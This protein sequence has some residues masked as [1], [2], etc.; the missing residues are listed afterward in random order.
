MNSFCTGPKGSKFQ[1]FKKQ[2]VYGSDNVC[3]FEGGTKF[4]IPSEITPYLKVMLY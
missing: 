2:K 1:T 4:E 3:L